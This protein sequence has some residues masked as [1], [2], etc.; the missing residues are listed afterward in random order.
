MNRFSVH[1]H[2]E[3]SNFRLIDCINKLDDLVREGKTLI[4]APHPEVIDYLVNNQIKF[5]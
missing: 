3:M 4:C 2:T 1:N 5:A